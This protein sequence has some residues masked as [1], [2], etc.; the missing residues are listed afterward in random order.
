MPTALI[1]L[2]Q[3]LGSD[4][5]KIAAHLGDT[6]PGTDK[7][8]DTLIGQLPPITSLVVIAVDGL[9]SANL[10]ARAGHAPT[11]TRLPQRRITTVTPSTTAAALTTLTTGSL[12]GSHGLVGYSIRHSELG[13]LS[14]LRDW[15]GIP[16]VRTWQHADPLFAVARSL[17]ARPFAYG[18]PAHASGGFTEAILTHATYV[19]GDRIADRFTA[20][21]KQLSTGEPT[22]AYIYVDELD[23]AGHKDGW[24]SET[25]CR[26]LEQLDDALTEFLTRLPPS[27]GVVLTADHGMVDVQPHQ[28]VILDL[29][30]AEFADVDM[31]GGEPRFRSFY[32]REGAD[33]HSFA[34]TLAASEGK[35][36]W[37]VS[38][39]DLIASGV[40]GSD[41]P[42]EIADRLGDVLLAARS[43]CAYYSSNDDP[44]SLKMIGQ[45][46]SWTDE[47]RGIPLI[48]AGAFNGSGFAKA[49]EA[50]AKLYV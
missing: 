21:N 50:L 27:V 48:L 40:L 23:R 24:Q 2:A 34:T 31:V 16:D 19:G 3:G 6:A 29:D 4:P 49:N 39:D 36:A 14:P 18:R 17:G 43:Q 20:A 45:H 47:E 9:G 38:R 13:L 10:R 37:V 15:E 26:R 42:R 7:M 11:L 30:A 1:S 44:Q 46:G 12:P 25:W 28:Q 22:F 5:H 32:L 35:R 33:P 8:I 41:V